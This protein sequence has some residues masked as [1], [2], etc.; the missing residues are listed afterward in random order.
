MVS[1]KQQTFAQ[2]KQ[3]LLA[4]LGH[5]IDTLISVHRMHSIQHEEGEGTQAVAETTNVKY[6]F[7]K[8]LLCVFYVHIICVIIITNVLNGSAWP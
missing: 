3:E 2:L 4:C 6:S 1:H 5:V 8:L 7:N